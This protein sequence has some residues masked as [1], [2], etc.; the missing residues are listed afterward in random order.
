M[1]LVFRCASSAALIVGL[2]G[3][4][5]GAWAQ[6]A[7]APAPEA[8]TPS[9]PQS[10][11]PGAAAQVDQT[12]PQEPTQGERVVVTGSLLITAPEDAPKP[13]ESYNFQELR[14]S[15]APSVAEF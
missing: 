5:H 11:Q 4:L 6:Q 15:G 13:V 1:K 3:G 7:P 8:L 12:A 9:A 10:P 14:E 2:A